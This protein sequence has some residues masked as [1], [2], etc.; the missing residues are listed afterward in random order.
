MLLVAPFYF[1]VEAAFAQAQFE[2]LAGLGVFGAA[3]DLALGILG[4]PSGT[5]PPWLEPLLLLPLSA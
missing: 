4:A 3:D 5:H 2:Q 1:D